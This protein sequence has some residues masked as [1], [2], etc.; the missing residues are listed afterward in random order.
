M[1]Y[2]PL[3][4]PGDKTGKISKYVM[5][6]IAVKSHEAMDI[7]RIFQGTALDQVA[8]GFENHVN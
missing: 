7:F 6:F 3:N 5:E 4:F 8:R 1:V 2:Q